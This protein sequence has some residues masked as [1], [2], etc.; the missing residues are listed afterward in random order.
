M[1]VS[2]GSR[3]SGYWLRLLN[4]P[5]LM[6][7]MGWHQVAAGNDKDFLATQISFRFN[8]RGPSV[9]VQ[10]AC[11]TSLLAT[12]LACDALMLGQCDVAVAGAASVA[13]PQKTGYVFQQ[14]GIASPD[15]LCRPFDAGANGSVLGKGVAAVVLKRLE[16]ATV[17]GD[18]IYAIIRGT[19][20]NNDG[21]TKSSFAA[22]SV[23]GQAEVVAAALK[24]AGGRP[25]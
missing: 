11:S 9:N 13:V 25:H 6:K 7:S 16:E 15:G 3:L 14:S 2:A 22:P 21:G 19:A 23:Q 18:R 4:K 1:S 12:A 5:D 10:A 8:L 20:V 17:D 24:R